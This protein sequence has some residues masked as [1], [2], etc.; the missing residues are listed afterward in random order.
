MGSIKILNK[1][2][3]FFKDAENVQSPPPTTIN[4]NAI[5]TTEFDEI[6]NDEEIKQQSKLIN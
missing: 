2:N 1:F 3:S 6:E 5:I 4:L